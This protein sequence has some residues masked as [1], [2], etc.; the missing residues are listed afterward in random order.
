MKLMALRKILRNLKNA[1]SLRRRH[2]GSLYVL[3]Q[4]GLFILF[5]SLAA[6]QYLRAF[7]LEACENGECEQ[8]ATQP[9]QPKVLQPHSETSPYT[10]KSESGRGKS[11]MG[12][13][14]SQAAKSV[15][16][17]APE[18]T[19]PAAL[20]A[21]VSFWF[22]IFSKYGKYQVVIHHR[23]FPQAVFR[24]VDFS[25][26]AEQLSDREYE[27][28]KKIVLEGEVKRV[29]SA[30]RS[31]AAGG[32]PQD[33]YAL[34][35]FNSMKR[36]PGG[37]EKYQK[38]VKD[39]LVRTQTGIKERHME[40]IQRSGRYLPVI[41]QIFVKEYGLP[42]ELTRLPFIESSFNYQAYS[43]VGAAGIWQFMP[44]TAK[45]YMQVNKLVDERRDP[46]TASRAAAQYLLSAHRTLGSWPLA[47]TSYNHG[48]AGVM[49]RV[50]TA[51]SNEI[52]TLVEREEPVFGFAS[53]N[54][55][56][57]FLAVLDIYDQRQQLFPGLALEPA[58]K[59]KEVRLSHS[60]SAVW[61]ARQ[62]GL[63]IED[64][65]NV[66]YAISES[67]WSGR[68]SIP[69][70]YM[71][72]V[73]VEASARIANLK[74]PE[75][76]RQAVVPATSAVRSGLV[77][78]VRKGD[79][80]SSIARKYGI[81]VAQ[82]KAANGL[83]SNL[84]RVGQRLTISKDVALDPRNSSSNAAQPTAPAAPP[85]ES[86]SRSSKSYTSKSYTV[87]SGDTL[88]AVA[89]KLDVSVSALRKANALK[90][91]RLKVGQVLQLP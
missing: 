57:E 63:Q 40:A 15:P 35:I 11:T 28:H 3:Q 29:E 24:V 9:P 67:V 52:V 31:F 50:R 61:A 55:Y 68:A 26:A 18:F 89:K 71:L 33:D 80:I 21:R 58:L 88:W 8:Q 10:V 79:T 2:A 14:P 49:R 84:V 87:R 7:S 90:S 32:K 65:R 12:R 36:V 45:V 41:E 72:K 5:L 30:L 13:T 86:S 25:E 62:L 59:L 82:L 54:F 85:A 70:G 47:L 48:V 39:E 53:A 51:G 17:R 34:A 23:H 38:A 64:L 66:N 83:S 73:P 27:K 16:T 19:V 42:V 69:A 74:A 81:S 20:R 1:V 77:Y 46:I 37:A 6:P 76:K 75:P 56:P 44:R 4:L 43:S 60:L 78:T 91:D 22:D